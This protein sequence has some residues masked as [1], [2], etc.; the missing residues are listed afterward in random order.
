MTTDPE[1]LAKG[2]TGWDELAGAIRCCT[3]CPELVVSRTKVV[4]GIEPTDHSH[5]GVLLVGE[6]PGAQ[7]DEAGVPFVGRS[8][9]LLDSLLAEAGL[10]RDQ[11][12]VANVLKCRPPANRKPRRAEV[13]RCRPWLT[14]QIELADPRVLVALGGT[15]AE[16]FFGTGAR[17]AALRENVHD[18]DGRSL[19][20]TYH[21]S[22]AIRFGPNGAPLAALRDDLVR[23]S[24]LVSD[25][26]R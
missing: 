15:A 9:Q 20:V 22:A 18:Y 26:R 21:P 24:R 4:P 7:E 6:A 14:R 25:G 3:A 12:G 19:V 17:I 23:V 11:V 13:A 1:S 5:A 16:W 8:G 2:A 10:S